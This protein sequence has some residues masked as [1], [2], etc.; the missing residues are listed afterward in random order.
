[1]KRILFITGSPGSGKTT[2]ISAVAEALAPY[3]PSGFL[4]LEIREG[5]IRR[6]FLLKNLGEGEAV[7]AH[8]SMESR[9]R[10]G[11]YGV[12]IAGLD[13]FLKET[14][15]GSQDANV[16]IIDEI[17]KME[18][19]SAYFRHR[20]TEIFDGRVPVIATIALK[21]DEFIE[22]VKKRDDAVIFYLTP[23]NRDIIRQKVMH[24]ALEL[25]SGRYQPS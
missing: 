17:G 15:F 16:I 18:C 7:L 4:T 20:L 12:D 25:V 22:A 14:F 8:S 24:S 2:L 9:Y 6:G 23:G 5:G 19:L 10:V 11:R 21:G 13:C 1:M 3:R